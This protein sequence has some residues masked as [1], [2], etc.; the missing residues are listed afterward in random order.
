MTCRPRLLAFLLLLTV[1]FP[2]LVNGQAA[3]E[4]TP[5]QVRVWIAL[6]SMP[7]LPSSLVSTLA[8]SLPVRST[9]VLGAVV[10]SQVVAAPAKLRGTLLKNLD[11]ISGE[12]ITAFAAPSDLEADKVYLAV[13]T[14]RD[15]EPFIRIRELDMRS[16]QLGPVVERSC[17]GLGALSL[18]LCDAVCESFTPLAR[19]EQVDD[20]KLT[21]R[22]RAGGLIIDQASPAIAE[23]G[24]VLRPIIR[25][26]DRSGQP[27]KGGIQAIPWSF[28]AIEERRDS[29]LECTL[30]SGY[31]S[32][33]PAKG[34][35]RMERLALLVRPRFDETRLVLRSRTDMSK[36]L[37]NYEIHQRLP[38]SDET[39]L[40]GLTDG[41]GSLTIYRGDGALETLV[42]K[43]G[44]QL[45]ARLPLVPG[46]E[47]S[48][49]A[50]VVDDDGRLAAEGY[51][52]A[53]YSRALDLVARREILAA[54]IRA[55]LKDG[56]PD[57]AQKLLDEF[58]RLDNRADLNRDLDRYRQQVSSADRV[59]EQRIERIFT[60]AQRL[61][62][63]KPLS[64][65]LLAQLTR[66]VSAARSGG[67]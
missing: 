24:M 64:D 62:L 43:N 6:D 2:A 17:N 45:L 49:T 38:D 20:R 7:Q 40:L 42:V 46:Y 65:E 4:Y 37:A 47:K 29:V 50:Y 26:N 59:T 18:A 28:L 54:R 34:G 55:R 1:G 51:V 9:S 56:K 61:L 35:I 14:R 39:H 60:D 15:G 57:E 66:E 48:L 32:A 63:L 22:L 23:P 44:K 12:A 31:R 3:W 16:R 25:R 41:R 58:R 5:Y 33:I 52:A 27:A 19:I 30:R 13:V 36:P 53:L 8:N 21:L 67:E 10:E 11:G